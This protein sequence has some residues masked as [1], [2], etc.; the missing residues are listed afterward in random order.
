MGREGHGKQISLV[1]VGSAHVVWTPVGLP[2]LKEACAS[3][4][5]TV[6]APGCYAEALSKAGPVFRALPK[7]KALRFSDSPQGHRLD[8][9]CVL[10]LSQVRVAQ[11]ARCL[12]NA[13]SQV[14]G[15]SYLPTPGCSVSQV[16]CEHGPS[17]VLCVSSGGLISGCDPPGR[18]QLSRITGRLG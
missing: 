4:I 14:G 10:C 8:W 9:M 15:A 13:L 6:Q 1:C 18:G 5:Y 3:W 12:M 7:S 2:Q 11:V 16:S 17:S